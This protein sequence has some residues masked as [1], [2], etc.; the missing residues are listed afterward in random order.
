MKTFWCRYGPRN[1]RRFT[2]IGSWGTISVDE[3]RG[4]AR[5]LLAEAQ[6]GDDPVYVERRRR[7]VPT[8]KDWVQTYLRQRQREQ[9]RSTF[10]KTRWNL[11]RAAELL[12]NAPLDEITRDDL[13]AARLDIAERRGNVSANRWLSV[14]RASLN[15]AA[16]SGHING[17][18]ASGIKRLREGPPRQRILDESEVT[19]LDAAVAAHPDSHVRC[20]FLMLIGT[21]ARRG[22]VLSAR[23]EDIDLASGTWRIP[24]PK[25][26]QPQIL[27]LSEAVVG[28]LQATP[29]VEGSP[30]LVPSS[31]DSGKHKYDLFREWAQLCTEAKI[32]GAVIHDLRRTFGARIA[33]T[34]GLHIASRLLRH[35]DIKV[36]ES[37]YAPI[38]DKTLREALRT[39]GAGSTSSVRG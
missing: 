34:A 2:T 5:D 21:G 18:P 38:D 8:F 3:A 16:A 27:P 4:R 31:R 12:G 7:E 25:S 29:R 36:T 9:K 28:M 6:L 26:G 33:R 11:D 37:V 10:W 17:N 19:R 35:K 24:D 32:E 30:W 1:R 23:W 20:A 15:E 22:E 13:Q 14:L 39:G